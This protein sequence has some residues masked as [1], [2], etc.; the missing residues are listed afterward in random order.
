MGE[1]VKLGFSKAIQAWRDETIDPSVWST[2]C[3]GEGWEYP[4]LGGSVTEEEI[5]PNPKSG[6][7]SICA[8]QTL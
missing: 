7:Q 3:D 6:N 2:G 8:G 1:V 4:N 5:F